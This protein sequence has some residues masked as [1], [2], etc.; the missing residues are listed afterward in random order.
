MNES[1][2]CATVINQNQVG[3]VMG[4]QKSECG[5]DETQVVRE[6]CVDR[7]AGARKLSLEVARTKS[8]VPI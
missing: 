4:D 8:A 1:S 5:E 7:A 6:N 3:K 2:V